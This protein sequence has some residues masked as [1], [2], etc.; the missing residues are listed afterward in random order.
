M[1][2]PTNLTKTFVGVPPPSSTDGLL[3][4]ACDRLFIGTLNRLIYVTRGS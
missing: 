4:C 1:N 2:D 3:S